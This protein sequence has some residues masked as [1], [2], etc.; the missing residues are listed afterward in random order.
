M[1]QHWN[2][3]GYIEMIANVTQILPSF[4]QPPVNLLAGVMPIVMRRDD[5]TGESRAVGKACAGL[6]SRILYGGGSPSIRHIGYEFKKSGHI[7]GE[8]AQMWPLP[9]HRYHG[10][11]S[12]YTA[13]LL[14]ARVHAIEAFSVL[15]H[16]PR[17]MEVGLWDVSMQPYHHVDISL[18]LNRKSIQ[19]PL[20]MANGLLYVP[21]SVAYLMDGGDATLRSPIIAATMHET[22]SLSTGFAEDAGSIAGYATNGDSKQGLHL[23]ARVWA[24]NVLPLIDQQQHHNV[25]VQY[26]TPCYGPAA[27]QSV[28]LLP[29]LEARF[30]LRT[31]MRSSSECHGY[32]G[33]QWSMIMPSYYYQTL[34]RLRYRS[35]SDGYRPDVVIYSDRLESMA[36]YLPANVSIHIVVRAT[37]STLTSLSYAAALVLRR[38]NEIWISNEHDL[39]LL[40]TIGLATSSK[41]HFLPPAIDTDLINNASILPLVCDVVYQSPHH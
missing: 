37:W 38:V 14:P 25:R 1:P 28:V 33:N 21:T 24:A 19:G 11:P 4:R 2:I 22:H 5:K 6:T 29:E 10:A 16:R 8:T 26:I 13:A 40:R 39:S 41:V 7:H 15:Y 3:Y 30:P 35:F 32:D 12:N 23:F 17:L 20:E 27:I 31:T 34:Q 9:V 18:R 36:D